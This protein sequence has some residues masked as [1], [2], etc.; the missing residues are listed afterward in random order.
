MGRINQLYDIT[1]LFKNED[2]GGDT[3]RQIDVCQVYKIEWAHE[4]CYVKEFA[5]CADSKENNPVS[6]V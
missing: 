1:Y 4:N 2:W 3:E 6:V 5:E